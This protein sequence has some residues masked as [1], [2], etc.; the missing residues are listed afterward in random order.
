M[1]VDIIWLVVAVILALIIAGVSS[2]F[3]AIRYRKKVVEA[4]IGSAETMAREIKNEALKAAEATKKEALLEIKEE[5]LKNQNE[6]EK[7]AKEQRAE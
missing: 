6:L 5:K 4:E 1:K 3:L 7:E 2:W